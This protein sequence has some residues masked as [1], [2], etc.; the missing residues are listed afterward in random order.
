MVPLLP[1]ANPDEH[2]YWTDPILC[3]ETRTRLEHFRSLHR[4]APSKLQ[5]QDPRRSCGCWTILEKVGPSVLAIC[6]DGSILTYAQRYC[7]Q[8]KEDYVEYLLLEDKAIYM[9]FFDW[10]YKTSWE[11]ALQSY[12]EYWR[13]LCQYFSLF[14]RRR[15]NENIREQMR[16]VRAVLW[17]P[18]IQC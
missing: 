10:M 3:E 16:R 11:K 8:S 6:W 4:V 12:D 18:H 15:M 2:Q 7:I 9:K 14:A 1:P 5:A 17:Y 13:R